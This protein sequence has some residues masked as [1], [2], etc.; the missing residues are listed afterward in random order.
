MGLARADLA[1]RL[2]HWSVFVGTGEGRG[3]LGL[4][5]RQKRLC[6]VLDSGGVIRLSKDNTE[7]VLTTAGELASRLPQALAAATTYGDAG[8]AMPEAY[9]LCGARLVDLSGLQSPEQAGAL[10]GAESAGFAADEPTVILCV[11]RR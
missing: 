8:A 6:R 7:V 5:P 2:E 1:A 3:W 4:A 9:V 11:R 10:V